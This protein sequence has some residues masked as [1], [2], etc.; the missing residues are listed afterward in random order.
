MNGVVGDIFQII[1]PNIGQ[2]LKAHIIHPP[3]HVLVDFNKFIKEH[4]ILSNIAL[5]GL[6]KYIV[7]I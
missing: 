7:L 4:S 6:P 2:T 1:I 3:T 5:D